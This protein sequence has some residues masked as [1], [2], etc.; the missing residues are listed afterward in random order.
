[1]IRGREDISHSVEFEDH[2]YATLD[3]TPFSTL[4][5]SSVN[6][7]NEFIQIPTGWELA[8]DEPSIAKHVIGAHP[9]GA[10]SLFVQGDVLYF[11]AVARLLKPPGVPGERR[12]AVGEVICRKGISLVPKAS[13]GHANSEYT[14]ILIRSPLRRKR[15]RCEHSTELLAGMWKE[16]QFTDLV[17]VC[18]DLEIRCHRAVVARGSPVFDRML[19]SDMIEARTDKIEIK[20]AE[21]SSLSAMLEYFYTGVIVEECDIVALL[22][23]ADR[24]Q[25]DALVETCAAEALRLVVCDNVV[26]VVRAFRPLAPRPEMRVLWRTL[27]DQIAGD[28]KLQSV[29]LLGV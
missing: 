14:R 11:T 19:N 5:P 10:L 3:S 2:R 17:I 23:L 7:Q 8:P 1:M 26:A 21:P 12:T 16:K 13:C 29:A 22:T 18:A 9:W 24:F 6:F 25:A 4:W 28:P 27:C 15:P 20:D